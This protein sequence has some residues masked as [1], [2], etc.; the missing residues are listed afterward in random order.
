MISVC[1]SS[2]CIVITDYHNE[3]KIRRISSFCH[4][5]GISLYSRQLFVLGV[6][7]M[8][9]L[10]CSSVLASGMGGPGVEIAKNIDFLVGIKSVTI[11]NTRNC[12]MSDLASSF[13]RQESSIGKNRALESLSQLTSLDDYVRFLRR[14]GSSRT[15]CLKTGSTTPAVSG[16]DLL[17]CAREVSGE[18]DIVDEVGEFLIREFV[19]ESTVV[20]S[21]TCAAFGAIAG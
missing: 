1:L 13:Y 3:S 2:W 6:D 14:Q 19:R 11:H 15:I 10:V 17:A 9:K 5:N 8:M 7:A 4:E 12:E 18:R 20:M 21:P 16:D